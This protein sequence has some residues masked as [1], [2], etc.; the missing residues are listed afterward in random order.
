[1]NPAPRKSVVIV[2]DDF[3][4][5]EDVFNEFTAGVNYYLGK[6]GSAGHRAKITL[7]AVYLPDGVPANNTGS[8][9]LGSGEEDQFLLRGQFQLVL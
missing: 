7:D 5:G 1:M 8:G 3:V 4:T 2:D 9:I 6:D